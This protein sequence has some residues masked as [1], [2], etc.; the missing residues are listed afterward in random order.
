M[1]KVLTGLAQFSRQL[2]SCSCYCGIL[3]SILEQRGLH[4]THRETKSSNAQILIFK[5]SR[6]GGADRKRERERALKHRNLILKDRRERDRER[7]RGTHTQRGLGGGWGNRESENLET[8][9]LKDSMKRERERKSHP[10]I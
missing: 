7:L 1:Q 8:L 6:E 3:I 2:N 4:E 10:I 5:D 9:I